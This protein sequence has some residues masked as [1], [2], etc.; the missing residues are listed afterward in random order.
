MQRA[1]NVRCNGSIARPPGGRPSRPLRAGAPRAAAAGQSPQPQ[2]PEFDVAPG[3][4]GAVA[5]VA[6]RDPPDGRPPE[7]PAASGQPP[8]TVYIGQY[9]AAPVSRGISP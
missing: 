1:L 6:K 7:R 8:T 4:R 2:S 5:G 9:P 3:A